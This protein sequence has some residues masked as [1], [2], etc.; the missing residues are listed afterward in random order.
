MNPKLL[1]FLI[2][3]LAWTLTGLSQTD[4]RWLSSGKFKVTLANKD[5]F[6]IS[7]GA[8]LKDGYHP[9]DVYQEI[10][11]ADE[12]GKR[13]DLV[14][15][16]MNTCEIQQ[17]DTSLVI[18]Y[19]IE[20]PAKNTAEHRFEPVVFDHYSY[21]E[22][23]TVTVVTRTVPNLSIYSASDI[24]SVLDS[25]EAFKKKYRPTDSEQPREID[26][27]LLDLFIAG[28]SGSDVCKSYLH[29]IRKYCYV[30][31]INSDIL[32]YYMKLDHKITTLRYLPFLL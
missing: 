25:F 5:V 31:G 21:K 22:D 16:W 7:Y 29:N 26:H 18:V 28:I 13:W 15:A 6:L 30:D 17:T 32:N 27:V 20:I 12:K 3:L 14:S 24:R 2:P 1:F 19:L 9:R 11:I 4:N 23:G 8:K 10:V